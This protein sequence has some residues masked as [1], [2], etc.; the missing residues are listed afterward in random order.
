MKLTNVTT[1][2]LAAAAG[3][4]P[5]A[6]QQEAPGPHLT[7][8]VQSKAG[9]NPRLA[10]VNILPPVNPGKGVFATINQAQPDQLMEANAK[11]FKV[12]F[13]T[14]PPELA[15]ATRTY[16]EGSLAEA[17]R[18]LEAVRIKYDGFAGLPDNPA[19]RA[20]RMEL[21]CSVRLMD[22]NSVRKLTESS[23]SLKFLDPEDRVGLE[24]ARILGKVSDDPA[25]AEARQKEIETLL[26]DANKTKHLDSVEYGWLKY[27]LGR[28]LA[29]SIPADQI[30]SG[31]IAEANVAKA[32]LAVD[33]L[34]EAAVSGHGRDMEL[35]VD[36]MVRAFN[37]LW[38]MP[39][40]RNYANGVRKMDRAVWDAG[41]HN[42]RDAVALAYMIRNIFAPNTKD[43]AINKAASLF[44]NTREVQK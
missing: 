30:K 42:F 18:Q 1:L 26:A 38:A 21:Q 41:N 20:A 31:N 11:D 27:A 43:E 29:S 23:P 33:A 14:T 8:I 22:W 44:F 3:V 12:F 28:A 34:C 2:L 32:S 9:K 35:P 13:I 10:Q 4:L 15:N 17:R 36:A 24:A 6:A 39:G 40:V 16:S 25:T 19:V 5:L 7:A 37:I